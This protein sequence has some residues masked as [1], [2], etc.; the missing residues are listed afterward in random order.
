MLSR[1]EKRLP[2]LTGGARDLPER[3]QTLRAAIAWSH[4]LLAAEE[5]GAGYACGSAAIAAVLWAARDLGA[6]QA[7]VLRY[8]TS[9]D[10][11][12]PAIDWVVGYGAAAL[13]EHSAS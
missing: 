1:L 6:R 7:A 8:G 2:L 9:G 5:Q 3:Q 10:I 12:G 11:P 4:D 13:W